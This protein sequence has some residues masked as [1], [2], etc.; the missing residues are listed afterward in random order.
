MVVLERAPVTHPEVYDKKREK[1]SGG[2]HGTRI[3]REGIMHASCASKHRSADV[4]AGAR[5]SLA[6]SL[7][8]GVPDGVF[9]KHDEVQA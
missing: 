5:D 1:M 4:E 3:V 6:R 2:G 8:E 9:E 7:F